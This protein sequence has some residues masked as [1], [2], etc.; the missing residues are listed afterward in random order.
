MIEVHVIIEMSKFVR[1]CLMTH[2]VE[3]VTWS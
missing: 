3:S 1:D 2:H